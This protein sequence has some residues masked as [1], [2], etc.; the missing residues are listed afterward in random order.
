[1]IS[2]V[3]VKRLPTVFVV[4]LALCGISVA[5]ISDDLLE[6]IKQIKLLASTRDQV[7]QVFNEYEASDDDYHN[8]TF[9][10]DDLEITVYYSSGNCTDDEEDDDAR[11]VWNVAEWLVTRI[12]IEPSEPFK[13]EDLKTDLSK[14]RKELRFSDREDSFVYHSKS[15]GLALFVNEDGVERIVYFPPSSQSRKVCSES[16]VAKEFYSEKSWFGKSEPSPSESVCSLGARVDSMSLSREHLTATDIK[17]I[18]VKTLAN[19]SENDVLTYTYYVSAGLIRGVGANVVWDLAG[20]KPGTYTI[21]VGVDEG[22]GVLGKT[23][24]KAVRID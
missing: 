10:N 13:A 12:E 6:K 2:S 4:I 3:S 24:T 20:V 21:T 9:S 16:T 19:D 5:Q 17:K 15:L 1:M 11:E 22:A 14:F 7:K 23:V 18:N 8:Q